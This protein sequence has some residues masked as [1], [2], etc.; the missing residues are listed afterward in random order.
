ICCAVTAKHLTIHRRQAQALQRI[1]ALR[2]IDTSGDHLHDLIRRSST[3]RS[4]SV[5][6]HRANRQL[7]IRQLSERTTIA[8]HQN[9]PRNLSPR[10]AEHR[11][12]TLS[13]FNK[14]V[15]SHADSVSRARVRVR[16]ETHITI[17]DSTLSGNLLSKLAQLFKERRHTISGKRTNIRNVTSVAVTLHSENR[18]HHR[19]PVAARS[20][21]LS[22]EKG[23]GSAHEVALW[24]RV[25]RTRNLSTHQSA[26]R[27]IRQRTSRRG[28][29]RPPISLRSTRTVNELRNRHA[30]KLMIIHTVNTPLAG[31]FIK[32]N[33]VHLAIE[34]STL[35]LFTVNIL[36]S[37]NNPPR[38]IVARD[39]HI[40][41]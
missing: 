34:N 16:R 36:A 25:E 29:F 26:H 7:F 31:L 4:S 10:L 19:I 2:R 30:T 1:I 15:L 35:A 24:H 39:N 20:T 27:R 33:R 12:A 13:T 41:R 21:S 14:T 38:T 22:Q 3:G 17:R 37:L 28:D 6:P 9:Q 40:V 32:P 8:H 11:L 5:T 23:L 18:A